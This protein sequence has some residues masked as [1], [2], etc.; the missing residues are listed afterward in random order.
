MD[1]KKRSHVEKMELPDHLWDKIIS[2]TTIDGRR[3][4]NIY[5]KID[6]LV[7]VESF[8]AR[9]ASCNA[10]WSTSTLPVRTRRHPCGDVGYHW[11]ARSA[12]LP[13]EKHFVYT[14]RFNSCL[15]HDIM[16]FHVFEHAGTGTGDLIWHALDTFVGGKR[17]IHDTAFQQTV[18]RERA[19]VIVGHNMI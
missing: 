19:A 3:A 12:K 7:S 15:S 16:D 6:T 9:F 1:S 8:N 14:H 10:T 5:R 18:T 4:A 11:I 2:L 13:N 17:L